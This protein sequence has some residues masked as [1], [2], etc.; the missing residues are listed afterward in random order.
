MSKSIMLCAISNI[1]SGN[2]AEDC[3][4]CTQSAH[5]KNDI[6]T[7]KKK[8]IARIVQEAKMAKQNKALG[9]CLVSSGKGLDDKKLEFVAQATK[10]VKKEVDI[11]IIACNGLASLDQLKELKKAGVDSYNHNLETSKRLYEKICSTHDWEQRYLTC[12]NVNRVG[13]KLC[14]GGIFGLDESEKDK[15][16]Y[17]QSLKNLNPF[18]TPINFFIPHPSLCIK[19]KKLSQT[20]AIKI[21][22]DVKKTLPNAKIMIAGGRELVFNTN[23]KA[24]FEA[25]VNAIVTGDYLTTKGDKPSSDLELIK[26]LGYEVQTDCHD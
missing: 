22:K 1:S 24:M 21:I 17:L 14:C 12:E 8:P 26:S 25:G 23:Q 19:P 11:M 10:A 7:Y 20:Q 2:C 16:Q 18:S 4:F 9:F 5:N 3:S 13:L 6:E 15:K